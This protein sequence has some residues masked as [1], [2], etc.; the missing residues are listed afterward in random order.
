VPGGF[1]KDAING[2]KFLV[3]VWDGAR[4]FADAGLTVYVGSR[5]ARGES[6]PS[7]R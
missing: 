2:I 4:Q 5:D 7:G 6:A 1:R 3:L